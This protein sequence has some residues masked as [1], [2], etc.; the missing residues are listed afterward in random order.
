MN[1]GRFELHVCTA[2]PLFPEDC[3]AEVGNGA[4]LHSLGVRGEAGLL[5]R[6]KIL[7]GLT[8]VVRTIQPDVLHTHTGL[9]W[10]AIGPDLLS[11]GIQGRILDIHTGPEGG[12]LSR[13]NTMSQRFMVRHM[14]YRPVAHSGPTRDHLA[15][16]FA[17]CPGSITLIPYG[18]ETA[19]FV[20]PK[21]PRPEWRRLNSIPQ[22]ALVVLYVARVVP[23]KNVALYLDV[24]R[25]VLGRIDKAV[26]LV[27]GDGPLRLALESSLLNDGMQERIRFLG[28]RHD[29]ADVYNASDLYLSTSN[30]ESSPLAILEAMASA[31]PVVA[32]DVGGVAEQ[33]QDG[34]T[35]RLCPA[36]DADALTRAT[37]ELLQDPALRARWGE[38]AQ[39]RVRRLFDLDTMVRKYEHL[40]ETLAGGMPGSASYQ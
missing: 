38:A 12:Q 40:Y 6:G 36:G 37:L 9:A 23:V 27:A 24:A 34:S 29:L 18:I 5:L 28:S 14:R 19:S 16:A 11:R 2:R 33:V 39:E 13:L 3:L 22:D 1:P 7:S 10:Y 15:Q 17:V 32:T 21:T 35:G 8:R 4:T 25:R 26:F 20:H 30:H 31:R